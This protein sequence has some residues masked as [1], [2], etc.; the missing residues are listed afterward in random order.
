MAGSLACAWCSEH[1]AD[2]ILY[3]ITWGVGGN[4]AGRVVQ[5]GYFFNSEVTC[6]ISRNSGLE[7]T[8]SSPLSPDILTHIYNSMLKCPA[9]IL[10]GGYIID[11]PLTWG[12]KTPNIANRAAQ[13]LI[14]WQRVATVRQRKC[15][16]DVVEKYPQQSLSDNCWSESKRWPRLDNRNHW[17][18]RR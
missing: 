7:I 2:L 18:V 4:G 5:L 12:K 9:K 6:S 15:R 3:S 8:N 14:I 17:Q 11:S 1:L 16:H 13:I 10:D